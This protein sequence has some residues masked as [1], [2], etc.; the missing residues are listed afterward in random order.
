MRYQLTSKGKLSVTV[1]AAV[2][3]LVVAWGVKALTAS[4]AGLPEPPVSGAPVSGSPDSV[5]DMPSNDVSPAP[6]STSS[7]PAPP[8]AEESAAVDP[9]S[10]PADPAGSPTPGTDTSGTGDPGTI[11]TS[12]PSTAPVAPPDDGQTISNSISLRF[13]ADATELNDIQRASIDT[14]LL[15]RENPYSDRIIIDC[16]S[17][18]NSQSRRQKA[19]VRAVNDYLTEV[20]VPVDITLQIATERPELSNGDWRID[21]YSLPNTGSMK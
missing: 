7:A 13:G 12:T 5:S 16:V 20:G 8:S 6:D 11:P 10:D 18:S 14:F 2:F 3:L 4:D 9:S 1:L 21:L 17:G 15:S 19:L